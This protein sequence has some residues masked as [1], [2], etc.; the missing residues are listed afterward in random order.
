M[1]HVIDAFGGVAGLIE[2]AGAGGWRLSATNIY[3]WRS[4][5]R[6]PS[7][8]YGPLLLI[9]GGQGA[10]LDQDKLAEATGLGRKSAA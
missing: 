7:C 5:G 1:N 8:W 6:I 3:K 2:V 4:T 10:A 9:A